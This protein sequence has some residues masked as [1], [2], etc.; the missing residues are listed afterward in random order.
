MFQNWPE[1]FLSEF[2]IAD[3]ALHKKE[4]RSRI[5]FK[6]RPKNSACAHSGHALTRHFWFWFVGFLLFIQ[7]KNSEFNAFQRVQP[8]DGS[9]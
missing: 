2:E 1:E 9:P 7:V 4:T 5:R 6:F 8:V 3:T